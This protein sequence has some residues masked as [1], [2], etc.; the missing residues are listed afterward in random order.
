MGSLEL[1]LLLLVVGGMYHHDY[2]RWLQA[3]GE[4]SLP[5]R[6]MLLGRL[7]VKVQQWGE[8][9]DHATAAARVLRN[10][11]RYRGEGGAEGKLGEGGG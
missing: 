7:A 4:I 2:K 8:A 1:L 6:E 5:E 11:V 9:R 10:M 3:D